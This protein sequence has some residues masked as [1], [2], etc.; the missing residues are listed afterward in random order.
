MQNYPE[1]YDLYFTFGYAMLHLQRISKGLIRFVL[2]LLVIQ[3]VTPVF[4]QVGSQDSSIQQKASFTTQ[5]DSAIAVAV[6][7]KENT[8][9]KSESDEKTQFTIELIDFSF[10]STALKQSHSRFYWDT[11][12]TR[13]ATQPLFKLHCIFLI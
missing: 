7:L 10:L 5:H 12:N 8:E 6:F 1:S 2:L 13:L 4:A 3:F 11:S 9:E